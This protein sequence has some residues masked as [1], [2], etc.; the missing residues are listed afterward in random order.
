[1]ND[2][3]EQLATLSPLALQ[4]ILV[5]F[6]IICM[7]TVILGALLIYCQGLDEENIKYRERDNQLIE[8]GSWL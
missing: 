3:L 4:I 2:I 8:K 5:M 6:I 7:L 1:M